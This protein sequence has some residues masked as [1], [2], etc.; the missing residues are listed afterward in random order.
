MPNEP[1][2]VALIPLR[3]GSK[4]IP[5]KNIKEI[6]GHPLAYWTCKAAKDS[7]RI[8]EVYVSTEDS[9]IKE[10]VESLGLGIKVID[11]PAEFAQDTSSTES[12]MLHFM[13]SVPFDILVTLQ[14]TSP[15]TTGADIDKAFEQFERDNLD[16]MLTGVLSKRFYWTREGKPLNYDPMARPRRQDFAGTIVENGAFYITKR[17]I[18]EQYKNRLGG[19]IGVY[20]MSEDTFV[21]IDEPAD[22]EIVSEAL[23]ARKSAR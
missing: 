2:I 17:A 8:S 1:K 14:A 11:R 10:A 22:W 16:S 4:S 20:E 7:P 5:Y 15:M 18:L 3:G 21:E 9:K 6:A 23:L 13:E 12:V 19:K